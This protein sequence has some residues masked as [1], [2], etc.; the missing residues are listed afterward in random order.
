M[1]TLLDTAAST[2]N[3]SGPLLIVGTFS[4]LIL[5]HLLFSRIF[6]SFKRDVHN[7]T[8]RTFSDAASLLSNPDSVLSRDGVKDSI[9]GYETLFAGARKSV[10]T[11]ST[12]DSIQNREKEYQKMVNSFYDLVTDFYEWGW[13]QVRF[14][15]LCEIG[16]FKKTR[17]VKL[18]GI[19]A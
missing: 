8:F 10:G 1:T 17:V 11:T 12:S 14:S 7:K 3:T 13:G 15:R 18:E 2:I 16:F 5:V 6:S 4:V 9:A 19:N